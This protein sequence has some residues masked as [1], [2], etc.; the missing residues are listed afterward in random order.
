[1]FNSTKG[2]VFFGTPHQGSTFASYGATLARVLGSVAFKPAPEL[3]R[4]LK[5]GR[6]RLCNHT[7]EFRQLLEM[8][9]LGIVSFYET[10]TMI[11]GNPVSI[12]HEHLEGSF[13]L[14]ECRSLPRS[15]HS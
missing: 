10:K 7:D 12:P 11:L 2:V 13:G 3:L 8:K 14:S 5:N 15:P 9:P 1:M 6:Q 4:S